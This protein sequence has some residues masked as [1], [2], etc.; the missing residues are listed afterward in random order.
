MNKSI[1]T[2]HS[3]NEK[4]EKPELRMIVKRALVIF[5]PVFLLMVA[6]TVAILIV[7]DNA[8]MDA[9]RRME[10]HTVDIQSKNLDSDIRQISSELLILAH[11]R[12][13]KKL[14][15]DDWNPDPEVLDDLVEDFLNFSI[16]CKLYDQVRL[17]DEIGMEIIRV[18]F[19]NGK[20]AV[21]PFEQ[22]QN[23]E[24]RYYFYDAFK[25]NPGEMFVS[26]FDLNI[27]H[28]KIEQPLKPMIRFATPV[29][30]YNGKKRG[31]VLFNY[32]GVKILEHLASQTDT[33]TGSNSMLLNAEGYWL[34][35]PE[36]EDEW[37]FM[38]SSRKEKTFANTYPE[39]WEM[40]KSKESYQFETSQGLF[41][42]KTV[43]PLL[44][45]QKSSTGSGEANTPSVSELEAKEYHWTV[46]SFVPYEFLNADRNYRHLVAVIVL[47]LLVTILSFGSWQ[48]A[49]AVVIRRQAEDD[50]HLAYE[51][52]EQ[53]VKDRTQHLEIEIKERKQAEEERNKLYV[54]LKEAYAQLEK[55]SSLLI[56]TEKMSAMGLMAAGVA[57]ELNNPMMG[58]LNFAQYCSKHTSKEDKR[59]SVLKDIEQE[60][61]RCVSIVQNLLT[62]SHSRK[63]KEDEYQKEDFNVIIERVLKLL[64]YRIRKQNAVV[65]HNPAEKVPKIFMKADQIQEVI[66]NLLTNALDALEES[67]KKEIDIELFPDGEFLQVSVADSGC[68]IPSENR[69]N[70]FDPFYTTKPVGKGTGLGLA[71]VQG[72]I[73]DH[74]GKITCESEAG[75][76]TRFRILLPKERRK[77][78]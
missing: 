50:L 32:F 24:E 37:G 40:I 10:Q 65:K 42:Y 70:I 55:Q 51:E 47:A 2:L 25:L 53:R 13:I 64:S 33:S 49:K 41:T 23:K 20:P 73:K 52:L 28:G 48:V 59:F 35:G 69:Q 1:G 14:W 26:P 46:V 68:G 44:E 8:Q 39:A 58:I 71:I 15:E 72:I 31:I 12:I 29:F 75:S 16:Y 19:N 30:D 21:T 17:L 9:Y 3:A 78:I 27:E 57:H 6:V 61:K 36:T 77:V 43:Y 34:M 56:Q 74:R 11:G 45:G 38:Y 60:T 5:L 66:L 76:G 22:L 62:F 54:D 4:R 67:D 63:E 7:S 18:N